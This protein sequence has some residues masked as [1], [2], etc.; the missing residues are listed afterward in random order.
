MVICVTVA[1]SAMIGG[2]SPRSGARPPTFRAWTWGIPGDG[3][4]P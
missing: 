2:A 1:Y 3:N 4:M